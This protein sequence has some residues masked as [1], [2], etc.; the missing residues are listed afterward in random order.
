VPHPEK[1]TVGQGL[2]ALKPTSRNCIPV[3]LCCQTILRALTQSFWTIWYSQPP[4]SHRETNCWAGSEILRLTSR[5]YIP[6]CVSYQASLRIPS[7][8]PLNHVISTAFSPGRIWKQWD[9]PPGTECRAV[10]A[11]RS[12][13]RPTS[14]NCTLVCICRQAGLRAA[15][16]DPLNHATSPFSSSSQ[17]TE[18]LNEVCKYWDQQAEQLGSSVLS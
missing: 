8:D 5:N 6:V 15:H 18:L 10:I 9:S 3:S 4:S 13:F 14:R 11:A 1:W 7:P 2:R 17:A 16:L 12:I